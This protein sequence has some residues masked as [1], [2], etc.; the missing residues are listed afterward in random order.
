MEL[1][2]SILIFFSLTLLF[3][4]VFL[5]YLTLLPSLI[6]IGLIVV[7]A[8]AVIAHNDNI[9]K[10]DYA[11]KDKIGEWLQTIKHQQGL[12]FLPNNLHRLHAD[13]TEVL[14]EAEKI[15]FPGVGAIKD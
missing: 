13:C 15:V 11:A 9:R 3:A 5:I 10:N 14:I 2:K 1:N 8:S 12:V 4:M 7:T 6:F